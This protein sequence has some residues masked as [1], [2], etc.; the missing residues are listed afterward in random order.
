MKKKLLLLISLLLLL[1]TVICISSCSES[2]YRE[3]GKEGYTVGIRFDAN[4]GRLKGKEDVDVV[5]LFNPNSGIAGENGMNEI[6]LLD[7]DDPR[8]GDGVLAA[9]K[10][11]CFLAGWYRERHEVT[12]ANGTVTGY[13]YSG[14]WDFAT[15]TVSVDPNGEYDPEQPIMTL[16]AAWIPYFDY[17]FYTVDDSGNAQLIG[18]QSQINLTLPTWNTS[19]GAL[20]YHNFMTLEGKTFDSAYY[21]AALTQKINGAVLADSEYVDSEK[22]IAKAQTIRIYTKW[23]DGEWFKIYTAEQF[24]KHS[25][26]LKNNL[27]VGNYIICADL[28]FSEVAWEPLLSF[29]TFGG[30]IR[31]EDPAKTYRFSNISV[32]QL[33]SNNNSTTRGLFGSLGDDAVISGICFENVTY[34]VNTAYKLNLPTFFGLLAGQKSSEATLENVTVTG[35]LKFIGTMDADNVDLY[36]VGKLFGLGDSNGIDISGIE[37]V[38]EEGCNVQLEVNDET[39]E[40]AVITGNQ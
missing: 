37:C 28:D 4:G 20:D 39:G 11:N 8:R 26:I 2:L 18:T 13:T 31:G 38:T 35:V 22:G 19:T 32:S 9:D 5:E 25:T 10:T 7:P 40:V 21:D 36:T 6:K 15:D 23:L 3:K 12:D 17:E 24:V 29:R 27:L 1:G 16:Y 14:K 30:T 33:A 34:T